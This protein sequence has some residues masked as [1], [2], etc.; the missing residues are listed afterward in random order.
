AGLVE[1]DTRVRFR[2]PLV[3]CAVYTAATPP[4]QR[5]AHR[6]LAAVTDP[7]V[8]PD[9]GAWHRAQAVLG[10]DEEAAAAL[11]RTAG[12]ARCRGGLAAAAAFMEHAAMLT[13]EPARRAKRALEAAHAKHDAGAPEAAMALLAVA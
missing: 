3:R 13:P 4:D 11:E 12:R 8:D 9:R 1:I 7:G 10:T 2:H 6:A 5:R